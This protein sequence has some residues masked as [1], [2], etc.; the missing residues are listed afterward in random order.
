MTTSDFK[1]QTIGF[2]GQFDEYFVIEAERIDTMNGIDY[3]SNVVYSCPVSEVDKWLKANYFPEIMER[4]KVLC[5][6][7]Y[8]LVRVG[9]LLQEP[10]TLEDWLELTTKSQKEEAVYSFI[11]GNKRDVV[12]FTQWQFDKGSSKMKYQTFKQIEPCLS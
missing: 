8:P 2:F 12:S 10:R 9:S 1:I 5:P 11:E 4:Q 6:M 7:G 3:A